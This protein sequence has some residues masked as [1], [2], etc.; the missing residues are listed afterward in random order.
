MTPNPITTEL[1]SAYLD[2]DLTAD[3]RARVEQLIAQDAEAARHLAK[4]RQQRSVM[5]SLVNQQPKLGADF[6]QRVVAAAF[7]EAAREG[8]DAKHPVMI[9]AARAA[10]GDDRSG[11]RRPSS[12][13]WMRVAAV[14]GS[15][16]ACFMLYVAVR[17]SGDQANTGGPSVAQNSH[18][19]QTHEPDTNLPG[20]DPST[21]IAANSPVLP[22]TDNA[23]K[24]N[25]SGNLDTSRNQAVASNTQTPP[26][27]GN[28]MLKD[29][30]LGVEPAPMPP[31]ELQFVMLVEV[32]LAEGI[33]DFMA[34]DSAIGRAGISG[35]RNV[36]INKNIL[37]QLAAAKFVQEQQ[38]DELAEKDDIQI[39]V[40]DAPCKRL[41]QLVVELMTEHREIGAVGLQLTMDD[42]AVKVA[43]HVADLDPVTIQHSPDSSVVRRLTGENDSSR[44]F[45]KSANGPKF[46][47]LSGDTPAMSLTSLSQEGPDVPGT[48]VLM[49]RRSQ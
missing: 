36:A 46:Q 7:A 19:P 49:V 48:I 16:A 28:D 42:S 13:R 9:A 10:A 22:A 30:T 39:M 47:K 24:P 31:Q 37:E 14:V 18:V 25:G 43:Q 38:P 32:E 40:I 26:S 6:S 15:L 5:R 12:A 44:W 2:G 27:V 34:V 3:E 29:G 11:G 45:R 21:A 4:L 17:Q 1:L 23:S 8:L 20:V 35:T 41:D 33:S